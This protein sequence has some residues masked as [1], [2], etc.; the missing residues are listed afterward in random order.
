MTNGTVVN[1]T[2]INNTTTINQ[3]IANS[4]GVNDTDIALTILQIVGLTLPALGIFFSI[5]LKQEE[6][7]TDR[8]GISTIF[9]ASVFSLFYGGIRRSTGSK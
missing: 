1:Q 8:P 6:K 3:T 5:A 4:S 2:I 7:L 9:F